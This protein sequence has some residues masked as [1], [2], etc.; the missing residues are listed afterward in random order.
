MS[1]QQDIYVAGLENRPPMLNKDN[2]VPWSSR[3]LCYAKSKPNRKLLV[4]SIL[5]GPYQY[6]MN[7]EPDDQNSKQVEADDQAIQT[8]LMGLPEDIYVEVDSCNSAKEVW[9]HVQQMMKEGESV[10]SYYHRLAKL[11]NYLDRN[12]L[13]QNKIACN[14]KL[15]NILQL[16]WKRYVTL[17]PQTKKLH[18]VDYNQFYDYLKQMQEDVNEVRA[19]A[20][21]KELDGAEYMKYRNINVIAARADGNGNGNNANQIRSKC[22]LHL[23]GQFAANINIGYH[24]D[25][26]PVYDSDGSTKDDSNVIPAYSSMDPNEVEQL[27]F[28]IE[29]TCAFYESLYNN[30]VIEVEKVN[31]VNRETKEVNVHFI[32]SKDKAPEVIIKFLKQIQV[33]LQAPVIIVRT[34]NGTKFTNQE[35]K[36]YFEDV[37]ISHQTSSV[38]TPQNRVVK[39]RNETLVEAARMMRIFSSA[40]DEVSFYTLFQAF[41]G[42]THDLDSIREET[43]QDCNF[44][45]SAFKNRHTMLGDGV[46]IPSDAVRTYKER[47]QELCDGIRM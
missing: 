40:P 4:K 34:D 18:D 37:G 21:C 26:A 10:E 46:T 29:E 42:N 36:A 31:T 1:T 19:E 39:R 12:H 13:T 41:G 16:D 9:L 35:L 8:I 2:Y 24:A 20:E 45:R 47:H 27:L 32:I 30:L 38:I 15:V 7:E 28:T 3:L 14:L 22:K 11:M 43:G 25:N 23:N 17:V 33:L 5:E 44:T 6:R